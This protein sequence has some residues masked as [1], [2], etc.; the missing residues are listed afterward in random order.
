MRSVSKALMGKPVFYDVFDGQFGALARI[1]EE[2]F[3]LI[4][5]WKPVSIFP[6]TYEKDFLGWRFL[7]FAGEEISVLEVLKVIGLQLEN[8][9]ED[10]RLG[11]NKML[12]RLRKFFVIRDQ[13]FGVNIIWEECDEGMMK[14][15]VKTCIYDAEETIAT[16][17]HIE[18]IP[19][20]GM[21]EWT[22]DIAV[23]VKTLYP[24]AV[25]K[26]IGD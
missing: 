3:V 10:Y 12:E 9:V 14:M 13:V 5:Q 23:P 21:D 19:D 1:G 4:P 26:T 8:C 25:V 17:D 11:I 2:P 24:S 6:A 20:Y 22:N 7:G 18:L 16:V 15:T